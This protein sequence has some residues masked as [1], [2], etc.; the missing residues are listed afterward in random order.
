MGKALGIVSAAGD[1]ALAAAF[2]SSG[3]LILILGWRGIFMLWGSVALVFAMIIR[4]V[5]TGSNG[6]KPVSSS[7]NSFDRKVIVAFIPIL[8]VMGLSSGVYRVLNSF[9]TTYL[10]TIGLNIQFANIVVALMFIVGML[11]SIIGGILTDRFGVRNALLILMAM[12]GL[13]SAILSIISNIYLSSAIIILMGFPLIGVWPTLYSAIA[14]VT[15]RGSR[16]FAYG[17]FLALSQS[18]GSVFPFIA[19]V[20]ADSFGLW[21]IFLIVCLLS[22][23][24]VGIAY[25]MIRNDNHN[26]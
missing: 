3:F 6:R 12:L 17:L 4:L 9:S 18:F 1:L 14:N 20:C 5:L 11:G 21:I 23:I 16:A 13:L 24:A 8:V 10:T 26:P 19:G 15:N 2:A 22:L 25:S 7:L